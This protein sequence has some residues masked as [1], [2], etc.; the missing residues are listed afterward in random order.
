MIRILIGFVSGVYV[1]TYYNC[2]PV[3]GRMAVWIKTNLPEEKEKKDKK[4]KKD[5]KYGTFWE[6]LFKRSQD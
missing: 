1:G 2:K 3:L 6:E 5:K 4:D